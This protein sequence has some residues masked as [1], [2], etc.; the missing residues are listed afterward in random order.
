MC[1]LICDPCDHVPYSGSL[2]KSN[3]LEFLLLSIYRYHYS[4]LYCTQSDL[5]ITA[6]TMQWHD[7]FG[8]MD[9]GGKG[10]QSTISS[11]MRGLLRA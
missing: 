2:P 1:F 4:L 5:T 6:A 10:P 3:Q 11:V 9:L 8:V 7:R